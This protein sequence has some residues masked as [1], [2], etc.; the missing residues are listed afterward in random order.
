MS[1][2]SIQAN[3]V[4]QS[5]PKLKKGNINIITAVSVY[6]AVGENPVATDRCSLMLAGD[7]RT[8]R[9]P[10]SCSRIAFLAVKESGPVSITELTG[11]KAS[12][13]I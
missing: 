3:N 7:S 4:S 5:T 2:Y 11:V 1:S 10:V 12:C 8:L 13:S 6:F 9:M